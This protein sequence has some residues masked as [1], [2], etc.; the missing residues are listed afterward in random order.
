VGLRIPLV[1]KR[2]VV[3]VPRRLAGQKIDEWFG[4]AYG[5]ELDGHGFERVAKRRWIR[6]AKIPIREGIQINAVNGHSF[7]PAWFVSLD[8]VPHVTGSGKVARHRTPASARPDLMV[9]PFDEPKAY[10]LDTLVVSGLQTPSEAKAAIKASTRAAVPLALQWFDR[11]GDLS[12]LVS[13]YEEARS[14]PIVRHG[15]DT[16]VQHRLSYAFVL[17]AAGYDVLAEQELDLWMRRAGRD[18]PPG[19]HDE[20]RTLLRSVPPIG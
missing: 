3:Q 14:R 12:S 11:I 17:R 8:H 7:A 19:A 6:S 20:I 18:V 15:F 16:Y 2:T 9:D 1:R 10:D 5:Y 13:L 4:I